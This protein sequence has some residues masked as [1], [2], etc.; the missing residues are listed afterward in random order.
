MRRAH[1]SHG[2][3]AMDLPLATF[4]YQ[5]SKRKHTAMPDPSIQRLAR[6]PCVSHVAQELGGQRTTGYSACAQRRLPLDRA[7]SMLFVRSDGLASVDVHDLREVQ[8][9]CLH[10][11]QG[12][13]REMSQRITSRGER[14]SRASTI[15]TVETAAR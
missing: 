13:Q 2:H 12:V 4:T 14:P 10:L 1:A 7:W 11:L 15:I 8:Q 3:M 5:R 9:C 6:R